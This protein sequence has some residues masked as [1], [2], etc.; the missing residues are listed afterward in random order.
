MTA[1]AVDVSRPSYDDLVAENAAPRRRVAEPEQ[2]VAALE[3]ALKTAL[4][5]LEAA[6]RAGKRHFFLALVFICSA[7]RRTIPLVFSQS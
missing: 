4:G 6:S 1:E 3:A 5:Q 7:A 2:H